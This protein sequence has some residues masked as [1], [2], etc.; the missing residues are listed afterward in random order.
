MKEFV[1][2]DPFK[3]DMNVF[4]LINKQWMLVTAGNKERFNTMTASWGGMGVLWERPVAFVFIRPQRYT[5]EFTEK[6]SVMTLSFFDEKFRGALNICGSK[7]GRD[8]DKIKECGLTPVEM[9][10]GSMAFGEARVILEC[11]KLYTDRLNPDGFVDAGICPKMYPGGD[12]HQM[13]VVEI[14]SFLK[15]SGEAQPL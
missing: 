7:S 4:K 3:E 2:T 10:S 11:R 6:E 12:F 9:P 1:K 13:Y 5:F 14:E 8:T 15:R